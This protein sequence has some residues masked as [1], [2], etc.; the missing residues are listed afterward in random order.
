MAGR[1]ALLKKLH[2]AMRAERQRGLAG[3]WTYSLARHAQL[4]VAFRAEKLELAGLLETTS[5]GR[6]AR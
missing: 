5:G 2:R 6:G 1:K 3:H 4:L